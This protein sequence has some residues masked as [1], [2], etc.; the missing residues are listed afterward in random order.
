ME[1]KDL[2]M[3]YIFLFWSFCQFKE[4][5]ISIILI[6]RLTWNLRVNKNTGKFLYE[7]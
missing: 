6:Y 4:K 3:I 5:F 7:V 2:I 1:I